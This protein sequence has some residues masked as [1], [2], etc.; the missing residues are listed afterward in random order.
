MRAATEQCDP[1]SAVEL[2]MATSFA[3][4]DEAEVAS[5]LVG[6]VSIRKLFPKYGHFNGEITGFDAN[7]RLFT[8]VY[9]DEDEEDMSLSKLAQ[10]LPKE[11]SLTVKAWLRSKTNAQE[12]AR[13]QG[14]TGVVSSLDGSPPSSTAAGAASSWSGSKRAS[15]GIESDNKSTKMP[16]HKGGTAAAADA[17]ERH[18]R[19]TN[20]ASMHIPDAH[21]LEAMAALVRVKFEELENGAARAATL[22]SD[23]DAKTAQLCKLRAH[24]AEM[25]DL[26]ESE[27]ECCICMERDVTH[28]FNPCGRC[29]CVYV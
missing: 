5:R 9:E 29:T 11:V 26:L 19:S 10:Y 25:Q 20:R 21:P 3:G 28:T 17:H 7:S 1:S 18:A 8:I 16:R 2:T 12:K 24:L 6:R 4:L 23:F 13:D 14:K 15:G 27:R 22:K